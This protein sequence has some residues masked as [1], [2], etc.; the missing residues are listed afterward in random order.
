MAAKLASLLAAGLLSA[1]AAAQC[2]S[3]TTGF[4]VTGANGD[5]TSSLVFEGDLYVGGAFTAFSGDE[6]RRL[7]RWSGSGWSPLA[8]GLGAATP[9]NEVV[10]SLAALD[11]GSG[12]ELLAGG[13]FDSAGGLPAQDVARW[14]GA[15]WSAV[16]TSVTGPGPGSPYV[17]VLAVFDDG[18]GPALF[19]G[20]DFDSV[21]GVAAANV[22]RW[23]GATWSDVGGGTSGPVTDLLVFDEG[24]GPA[25]YA[26]YT[27]QTTSTT[28]GVSRWDGTQ[29]IPLSGGPGFGI[30]PVLGRDVGASALVLGQYSAAWVGRW[31]GTAW[32]QIGF[33]S[34]NDFAL[35]DLGGGEQLFAGSSPGQGVIAFDGSTWSVVGTGLNP[36]STETLTVHDFGSGAQLFAGG[37]YSMLGRRN[38]ARF[39]GADWIPMVEDTGH[40]NGYVETLDVLDMGNGPRL[41]AGGTFSEGGGQLLNRVAEWNGSTW[42]PLG[43]GLGGGVG[44]PLV[45][46]LEALDHGSGPLLYVTGTF[47]FAGGIGVQGIAR[48]DG[49][50]WSSIGNLEGPVPNGHA[51]KVF[52][53]GSGEALYVGGKFLRVAGLTVNRIARFDGTAWS[54]VAGGVDGGSVLALEVFDDGSGPALF[55]GGSFQSAGGT[56]AEG[57][58]RWDGTAWQPLGSGVENGRISALAVF[59]DGSGPKLWAG[60]N[61]SVAGGSPA[62]YLAAWDGASWS[63]PPGGAPD[64]EVFALAVHDDG[65]GAGARLYAGGRFTQVGG[66]Q[67]GFAARFD[68]AGWVGL[69]GGPDDEVYAL[70]SFDDGSRSGPSLF[71]GGRFDHAGPVESGHVARWSNACPCQAASYCT[72]GT[73]TSG[74]HAL[75][76]AAGS[77]SASL[78]SGFDVAVSGVEG[79]KSGLIFFGTS[80]AQATPW[81][82][83]T[84]WFC[85]KGPHLRTPAQ[86]AGGTAG[87]CNGAFALDFNAWMAANPTKSPTAGDTVWMQAWF[88]D[89][90]APKTT[91]LSD[92]IRFS[93]CP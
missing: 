10:R 91:S 85:V 43:Q 77:A 14:D 50:A 74:C 27:Y 55:A 83:G 32:T 44:G 4:E 51:L 34:V 88:R 24:S 67:T 86:V 1:P 47:L 26:A 89:P 56:P 18:S 40:L 7:A 37:S 20:G 19:A 58:A 21:D 17:D 62:P 13:D 25:L 48:W 52:D 22:A 72:A 11:L 84:S 70:A 53:D 16:A 92:A 28:V 73:T 81:G 15:S 42:L 66:V 60:G 90:P 30:D 79:A 80:G 3:W 41:H 64:G 87:S 65:S 9:G 76:G 69:D 33:E 35:H 54:G 12:P 31:G 68:G 71:V 6:A 61:F 38:V 36:G 82:A 57:I 2:A 8:G 49:A 59:D 39:D 46:A 29:W 93:V 63:V 45:R 75:I 78:G 23:D 5:V